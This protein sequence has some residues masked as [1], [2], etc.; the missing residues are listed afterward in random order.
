LAGLAGQLA[1]PKILECAAAPLPPQR[2]GNLVQ[3]VDVDVDVDV[4]SVVDLV[5]VVGVIGV[6][7]PVFWPF[8][9]R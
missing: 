6:I 8:A 5:S 3:H 7:R 1:V 9:E 2:A 4:V